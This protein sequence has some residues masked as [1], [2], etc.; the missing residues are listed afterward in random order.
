MKAEKRVRAVIVEDEPH[1]RATLRE[2]ASDGDWL[3]V[4]G[5]AADGGGADRTAARA[6]MKR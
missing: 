5:E 4:V 1:A 2:Y 3:I 6:A